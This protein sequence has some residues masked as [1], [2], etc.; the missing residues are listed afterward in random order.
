MKPFK[1]F[2]KP[3]HYINEHLEFIGYTP[4][5]YNPRTFAPIKGL[6][7]RDLRDGSIRKIG[8]VNLYEADEEV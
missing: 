5:M 1:F 6:M 4:T 3:K 2:R 8:E 7:Y